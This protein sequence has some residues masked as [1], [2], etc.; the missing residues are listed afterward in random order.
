MV[1]IRLAA[2]MYA[3]RNN[4][5]GG[6]GQ[7]MGG[8]RVGIWIFDFRLFLCTPRATAP[9]VNPH[10]VSSSLELLGSRFHCHGGETP[11]T[12]HPLASAGHLL[13]SLSVV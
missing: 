4:T 12:L 13:L 7:E 3:H 8:V 6:W 5:L 9:H 1:G 10:N 2:F 11:S